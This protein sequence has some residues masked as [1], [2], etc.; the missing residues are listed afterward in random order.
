MNEKQKAYI[1]KN[2]N[3]YNLGLKDENEM[4]ALLNILESHGE[5]LDG[6]HDAESIICGIVS[7]YDN[8][9]EKVEAIFEYNTFF[10]ES[11]FIDWMIERTESLKEDYTG[12]PADAIEFLREEANDEQD[13]VI[14]KTSDGYVFTVY[15]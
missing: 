15:C 13:S 1:M 6:L 8:D 14:T 11:D 5:T 12:N 9:A 2:W 3:E 10:T 7:Q 4:L